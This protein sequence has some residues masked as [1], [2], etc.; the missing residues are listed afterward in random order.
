VE[1]E[2]KRRSV[3]GDGKPTQDHGG[4]TVDMWPIQ[5]M[6]DGANRLSCRSSASFSG[7]ALEEDRPKGQKGVVCFPSEKVPT[8]FIC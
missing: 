1:L 6:L 2:E 8:K 3:T 4:I 7:V 5:P